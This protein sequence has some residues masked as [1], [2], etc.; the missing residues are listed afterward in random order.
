MLRDIKKVKCH[1]C[2]HS[3]IALD[4]EDNASVLSAPIHCPECGAIYPNTVFKKVL[5]VVIR[6]MQEMIQLKTI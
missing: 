2:G 6:F 5:A 4:I 3:F 1:Q